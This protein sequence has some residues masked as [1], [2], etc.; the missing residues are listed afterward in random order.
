[1]IL[2]IILVAITIYQCMRSAAYKK[3]MKA[4]KLYLTDIDAFPDEETIR[5]YS[6]KA[7]R[8]SNS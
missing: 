8:K 1:M 7:I 4:L 5:R 6:E 2:E 3:G